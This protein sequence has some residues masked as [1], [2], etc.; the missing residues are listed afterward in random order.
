MTRPRATLL[1]GNPADHNSRALRM[2]GSLAASGWEVTFVARA[3][4]GLPA[5][6]THQDHV[7]V[8]IEIPRG[9]RWLPAPHLPGAIRPAGPPPGSIGSADRPQRRPGLSGRLRR[10]LVAGPGRALQVVRYLL[11]TRSWASAVER[12]VGPADVWQADGLV[13]LPVALRLAARH[14][15]RVVY[16]SLEIYTESGSFARLPGPWRWLLAWRERRWARAADAVLTVNEACA[17][18]LRRRLGV[19]VDVVMNCAE[20][21]GPGVAAAG[22]PR[23][24]HESLGLAQGTP[25]VLYHGYVFAHRGIEG[26]FDAIALVPRAVLVVMGFGPPF[27]EYRARAGAL[28]HADRVHVIPGVPP[29]DLLPWVASADVVAVTIEGSTLNHRLAAPNKLFEALSAGVPVVASDFPAMAPIIRDSG[30]G[31]LCDPSNP[32]DIA[33]AIRS[34]IDAPPHEQE[35]FRAR[36]LAAARD[37]YNWERQAETYLAVMRRLAPAIAGTPSDAVG[38]TP[39]TAGPAPATEHRPEVPT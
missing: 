6:E 23:R 18:E 20:R 28:P 30:A 34:I 17:V 10:M 32:A 9:P 24:F 4:P 3:A 2:A 15:G 37:T 19:P 26:L 22:R 36:A 35:A 38:A 29:R 39:A 5:T 7:V 11:A 12:A 27:D 1:F 8:R 21:P 31:L 33:R 14:G 25:V 16:D 13:A